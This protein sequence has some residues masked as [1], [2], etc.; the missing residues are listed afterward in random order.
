MLLVM[1]H[2]LGACFALRIGVRWRYKSPEESV[3]SSADLCDD[4]V[5]MAIP[6]GKSQ[7]HITRGNSETVLTVGT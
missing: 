3:L 2:F 1:T 7:L 6:M 5:P 4:G